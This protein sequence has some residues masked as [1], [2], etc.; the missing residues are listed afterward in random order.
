MNEAQWLASADPRQMIQRLRS[1]A[2][3]RKLQLFVCAC[4]RQAGI[5]SQDGAVAMSERFVEGEVSE[6]E[7]DDAWRHSSCPASLEPQ[8][9]AWDIAR[10]SR[11]LAP[12]VAWRIRRAQDTAAD[13]LMG[14]QC[15]LLREIF[16]N[17]FRPVV[18]D[19][20]WLAWQDGVI[21]KL[22]QAIYCQRMFNHLPALANTL[23]EAGCTD[24]EI[25]S[26][27]RST[28]KHVR[29]CWVVDSLLEASHS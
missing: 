27:C 17:P 26:H 3:A 7:L 24:S 19:P 4:L 8:R 2:S 29:G 12:L 16:G 5:A 9:M 15:D 1:R 21:P 25:L 23:N 13:S 28:V 11:W 6:A 10:M 22:A 20:L 14:P 18:I